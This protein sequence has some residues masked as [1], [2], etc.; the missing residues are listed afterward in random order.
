LAPPLPPLGARLGQHLCRLVG[1]DPDEPALQAHDELLRL[2]LGGSLGC[3][4]DDLAD[5]RLGL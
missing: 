1:L 2:T 3:A 4:P 5:P